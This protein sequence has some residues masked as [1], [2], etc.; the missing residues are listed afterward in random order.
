MT[1]EQMKAAIEKLIAENGYEL[2]LGIIDQRSNIDVTEALAR[3]W[4]YVPVA[5]V[6]K[7]PEETNAPSPITRP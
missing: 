4:H 5:Q 6:V 1:P 2:T 7:R 3:Q